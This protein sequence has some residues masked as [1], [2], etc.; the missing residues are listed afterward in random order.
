MCKL[1][2][3]CVN[4]GVNFILQ[5]FCLCKKNDKY[6]VCLN[7]PKVFGD[8]SI[9]MVL[10]FIIII[11]SNKH[12]TYKILKRFASRKYW[13]SMGIV[14]P[15]LKNLTFHVRTP[16]QVFTQK[17]IFLCAAFLSNLTRNVEYLIF[18]SRWRTRAALWCCQES[19]FSSSPPSPSGS[20][21]SP[22]SSL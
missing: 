10:F 16:L 7:H 22:Y 15:P 14:L 17:L 4:V 21:S 11:T 5:N 19:L 8:T 18:R 12:S 1:S 3:Y 6:E 13:N 2:I 9:L 20:S